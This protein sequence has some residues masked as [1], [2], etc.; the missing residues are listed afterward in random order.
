MKHRLNLD[1]SRQPRHEPVVSCR[2]MAIREKLLSWLFGKKR[3][4]TIVIP[5]QSVEAISIREIEEGGQP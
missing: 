4:V 5:G 2:K 3:R 1:V